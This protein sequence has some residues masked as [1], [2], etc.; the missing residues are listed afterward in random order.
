MTPSSPT[1]DG[2]ATSNSPS[3]QLSR[4][5]AGVTSNPSAQNDVTNV[6]TVD[7]PA[8]ITIPPRQPALTAM[9]D[10]SN[11]LTQSPTSLQPSSP[12][13]PASTSDLPDGPTRSQ[14]N[15]TAGPLRSQ[16][17][18]SQTFAEGMTGSIQSLRRKAFE[19][20]HP[21]TDI[22]Q[23]TPGPS[24][25]AA[26][27]T[28]TATGVA[29]PIM[30]RSRPSMTQFKVRDQPSKM[31]IPPPYGQERVQAAAKALAAGIPDGIPRS[32][33]MHAPE[34]R[35][36]SDSESAT[37]DEE[38]EVRVHFEIHL[39]EGVESE[40]ICPLSEKN[41]TTL[42]EEL[43]LNA[44][45]R[46]EVKAIQTTEGLADYF[47]KIHRNYDVQ[48]IV[49]DNTPESP[50]VTFAQD[51]HLLNGESMA[52]VR[53]ESVLSLDR[54]KKTRRRKEKYKRPTTDL[55]TIPIEDS[56][57]SWLEL[58]Y[59]L[60]FVANL[61]DFTHNHPITGG[62][63]L[64][65][66]I[67]WFVIMWWS[68]AG[69]TFWAAR[70]DMDDLFTKV[71][72][73]V[74]FCALVSFG[75]FSS[76]HLGRT[77]TG[78]IASYIVLKG[79]L[80]I[81]YGNVLFW[82]RKNRS[83][84]SLTPLLL[85]I[86]SNMLAMLIWGLSIL[87]HSIAW[88][89]T[90]WYITI[91]VE[92]GVLVSFGRRTSVTF[93]GSHL[94]ERFALFTILVLG[95]NIIGLVGLSS[96]ASAWVAGQDTFLLLF[97]L[98]VVILY[99]LWW[100]YFDDFSE[101][102]F[103]KTT[104]L[105]QFW[106]YLHLPFHV[107]I[108]LVGTGALDLIRLYKLEHHITDLITEPSH[109]TSSSLTSLDQ[110]SR[111]AALGFETPLGR[112]KSAVSGGGLEAGRDTDYN[113]TKQYFLVACSLVFLFSSLIKWINLRSYD[114]FQ[115]IVYLSRFLNSALI[116]CLIAVPLEQMTPFA[117]LGIMA[118]FCCLQV[119]VDL[120]VIY[121][122][123]YGFIEDLEAWARSARSSVDLG[124][125]LPSP[126]GGRS[127]GNSRANS[128]AGSVVNLSSLAIGAKRHPHSNSAVN[129]VNPSGGSQH[130]HQQSNTSPTSY[131]P[132]Q[133]QPPYHNNQQHLSLRR[134]TS[135]LSQQQQQEIYNM[136]VNANSLGASGA[137]GNLAQALAEIKKREQ[138]NQSSGD[139]SLPRRQ[140]SL[141]AAEQGMAGIHHITQNS[142][143]LKRP[144]TGSSGQANAAIPTAQQYSGSSSANYRSPTMAQTQ[145]GRDKTTASGSPP[146]GAVGLANLFDQ[147]PPFSPRSPPK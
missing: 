96:G 137:Y 110:L 132:Q 139:V 56:K 31:I 136:H 138:M 23:S 123:A 59:D 122:G 143:S 32:S 75:A 95:E 35:P 120:A 84:K 104:M 17:Q 86:G 113:L 112:V 133:K 146:V 121:F 62:P 54:E 60:L 43:D 41:L 105:S 131:F 30:P 81:E 98:T 21:K 103:H 44:Q 111:H 37:S 13:T 39:Q 144:G 119:A 116:L 90:M 100:L 65:H 29:R 127:R 108:V 63:A 68:W 10:V 9:Q 129:L 142:I 3:Q 42:C 38:L 55:S 16:L 25:A 93:A 49:S 14:S 12:N 94:P 74:E 7:R 57:A 67:G 101:D 107:C 52:V 145:S 70:Y 126:L 124:S 53:R 34:T 36:H 89:Y 147:P 33:T 130:L 99:A 78:F 106:A 91:I 22:K 135:R 4:L 1:E 118:F 92:V 87:V 71:W 24:S 46:A 97:F 73:L 82:A 58:F 61:T 40:P 72:K 47:D 141:S 6:S 19:R 134:Q 88:R 77:S 51:Q 80:V 27:A 11:Q 20:I 48:I 85:Q 2:T 115:K 50:G 45:E 69:Q 8:R 26:A 114:K 15:P 125:F 128:R 76:D 109:M 28:A 18:A 140:M 79:V 102:I 66:Y 5:P 64:G 83:A 117:L